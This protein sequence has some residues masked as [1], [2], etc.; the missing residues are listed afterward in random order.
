MREAAAEVLTRSPEETEALARRLGV[1]AEKGLALCL[2]GDLGAGKTLFAQGFARGLG[3][4]EEV[5]S[6]TFNLMNL[7]RGRLPLV[8]FDLY[9]LEREEELETIG[10]YEYADA[11][12]GVVLIEWADKFPDAMPEE[13]ICLTIERGAE[14]NERRLLFSAADDRSPLWKELKKA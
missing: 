14:E 2:A 1:A 3:V 12:E 10:F 9:R 13:C 4:T 6:P 11:P 8:H 5:T 7:Y